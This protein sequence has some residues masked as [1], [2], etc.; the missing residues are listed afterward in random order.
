MLMVFRGKYKDITIFVFSLMVKNKI[1]GLFLY[2]L[3]IRN[4]IYQSGK[5][6]KQNKKDVISKN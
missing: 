5:K 3:E 2:V 4:C 1:F 6:T